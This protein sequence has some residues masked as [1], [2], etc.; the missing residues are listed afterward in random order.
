MFI[1]ENPNVMVLR[2][3]VG[4]VDNFSISDSNLNLNVKMLFMAL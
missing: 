3:T 4:Y 1:P 2:V